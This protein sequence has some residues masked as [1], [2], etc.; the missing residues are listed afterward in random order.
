MWVR[1]GTGVPASLAPGPPLLHDEAQ[2]LHFGPHGLVLIP[3]IC[4][5]VC[6]VKLYIML[7]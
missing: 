2:L 7:F 4:E 5:N 6:L 3:R 1:P